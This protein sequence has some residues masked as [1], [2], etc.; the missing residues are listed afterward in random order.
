MNKISNSWKEKN[1]N[2]MSDIFW[3][4][5]LIV[6]VVSFIAVTLLWWYFG[7]HALYVWI[8]NGD[9]PSFWE[10]VAIFTLVSF[11]FGLSRAN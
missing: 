3:L 1:L 8:V 11:A 5:L 6:L 7:I 10:F 9:K 4:T 2:K